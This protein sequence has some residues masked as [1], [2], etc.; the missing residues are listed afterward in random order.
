MTGKRSNPLQR[1]N[2]TASSI[3]ESDVRLSIF[4]NGL[5]HIAGSDVLEIDHVMNHRSLGGGDRSFAFAL[6]GD[7][8]Q[9]F[10]R[11]E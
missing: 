3:V 7:L 11:S 6:G 8:F 10:A 5:H 4:D 9:L 2:S 1:L